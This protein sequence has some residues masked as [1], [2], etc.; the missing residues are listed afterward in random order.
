MTDLKFVIFDFDGTIADTLRLGVK[1]SNK[2]ALK[3]NYGLI[4]DDKI[5]YYRGKTAQ[6]IIKESKIPFYKFPFVAANFKKEFSKDIDDLK[7][8]NGIIEIV[9][10]L[11]KKFQLGIVTSNARSNVEKFLNLNN[12][13][14]FFSFMVTDTNLFGKSGN[15]KK[16]IKKNNLKKEEII[17]IGDET[18]DIEAAKKSGI[19]IISVAWGFNTKQVL[20][21]HKPDFLVNN[22][23]EL[24][25]LFESI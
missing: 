19:K 4:E 22:K 6:W 21:K 23:D 10:N 18:R 7:P 1:I 3:Y 24:I 9:E 8:I 14:K 17:Y 12:L 25:K 20:E 11:Y 16:L 13:K 5:E 2:L 15:I